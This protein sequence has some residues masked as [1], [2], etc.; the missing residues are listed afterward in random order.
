MITDPFKSAI[1]KINAKLQDMPG[2]YW[3]FD[4]S[5]FTTEEWQLENRRAIFEHFQGKGYSFDILIPWFSMQ[6]K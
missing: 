3:N 5:E 4:Q 6:K 1:N 2:P